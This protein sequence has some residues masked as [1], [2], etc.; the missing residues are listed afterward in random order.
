MLV[1]TSSQLHHCLSGPTNSLPPGVLQPET[2]PPSERP[3]KRFSR[4]PRQ[5]T[6]WNCLHP[7]WYWGLGNCCKPA[8]APSHRPRQLREVLQLS[9][10]SLSLK[11][12]TPPLDTDTAGHP[13]HAPST[14]ALKTIA[15]FVQRPVPVDNPPRRPPGYIC[16]HQPP[17]SSFIPAGDS[18]P[19]PV[20]GMPQTQQPSTHAA[21]PPTHCARQ[22]LSAVTSDRRSRPHITHVGY[23]GVHSTA[24]P[25]TAAAFQPHA[26]L[27][28]RKA[29]TLLRRP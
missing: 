15:R 11:S 13:N 6:F 26:P 19:I 28:E 17:Q 2:Y 24:V 16:Q 14:R 12:P 18:T 1:Q 23:F 21:P 7:R 10:T 9:P 27:F 3:V 8:N 25:P 20:R 5:Y 4:S 22:C 29:Q